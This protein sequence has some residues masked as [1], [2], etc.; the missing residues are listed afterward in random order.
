MRC[1]DHDVLND[2][3]PPSA[4]PANAEKADKVKAPGYYGDGGGLFLQVSKYG[5]KSW[6]F[7][8]KASGRLREMGLGSRSAKG[9]G[10]PSG[11]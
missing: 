4:A 9:M 7:R 6:V 8:F 3:N 10:A 5:C 11:P 2:A 1:V